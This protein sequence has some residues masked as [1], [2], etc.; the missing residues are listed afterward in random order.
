MTTP[1]DNAITNTILPG[2]SQGAAIPD[3]IATL[4][5]TPQLVMSPGPVKPNYLFAD[6]NGISGVIGN[7]YQGYAQGLG[8]SQII[9]NDND[10]ADQYDG[11]ASDDLD[12]WQYSASAAQWQKK[13][14]TEAFLMKFDSDTTP[15]LDGE[16]AVYDATN[17][18]WIP[19]KSN[20]SFS[21]IIEDPAN[22]SYTLLRDGF[23]YTIE[24][25]GSSFA[26]ETGPGTVTFPTGI[27][28]ANAPI[29]MTVSGTDNTT[30][31]LSFQLDYK[32]RLAP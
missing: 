17:G 4:T 31:F 15:P 20:D 25:I 30:T 26:F 3:S 22:R 10:D 27:I 14:Y 9:I 2:I 32:R 24:I 16:L 8:G 23:D 18:V 11:S 21:G 19:Q 1:I 5:D 29:T 28:L 12:F 6:G 13:S 7:I